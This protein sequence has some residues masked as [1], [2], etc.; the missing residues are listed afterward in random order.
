MAASGES[1]LPTASLLPAAALAAATDHQLITLLA[2]PNGWHRDTAS[3]LLLERRDKLPQA[4][5]RRLAEDGP[6]PRLV[7]EPSGSLR[8][9][10]D[11]STPPISTRDH[12][13]TR[14]CSPLPFATRIHGCEVLPF[15]PHHSSR[16]PARSFAAGSWRWL[17]IRILA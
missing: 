17:L 11:S 2:H 7:A 10:P 14:P 5:L 9:L 15:R 8:R 6:T 12:H 3:R 1:Q 13:L 4:D 16:L